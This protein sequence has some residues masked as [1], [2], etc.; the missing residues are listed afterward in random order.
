[1]YRLLIVDDEPII[2]DG[3]ID[4]FSDLEGFPELELYWAYSAHEALAC[5]RSTRIDIVLSDIEMPEMNGLSLQKEINQRWPRC[6][7]IFLTGYNDFDYIHS[8][9][10]NGATDYVLKTEGDAQILKAVRKAIEALDSQLALEHLLRK[11]E[12]RLTQA[13]PLLQREFWMDLL[14][15]AEVFQSITDAEARLRELHIPLKADEP[16]LMILGRVDAWKE[17]MS[18]SDKMLFLYAVHNIAEEYLQDAFRIVQIKYRQD[19]FVWLLQYKRPA[20]ALGEE[21]A[22]WPIHQIN[23]YMELIQASCSSYLNTPCSFMTVSEPFPWHLIAQRFDTLSFLFA[24]G[25]GTRQEVLLSDQQLFDTFR[26]RPDGRAQMRTVQLLTDF[27]EK[28][29]RAAFLALFDQFMGTIDGASFSRTGTAVEIFYGMVSMFI[30]YINRWALMKPVSD[31]F[32]INRLF[33]IEEHATWR[34]ATASFRQ[35]ADMLFEM[36]S[37]E[38]EQQSNEVIRKVQDYIKENLEGDL[39]LTRLAEAVYL[40]PSYLSKLYKQETGISLTDY[41]V[42]NRIQKAKELLLGSEQKIHKIGRSV[43]FESAAY[44]ARC[45]KKMTGQTPQEFRDGVRRG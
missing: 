2:V 39:S 19:R 8:S 44:F 21:T 6:K 15:G 14:S 43:G 28:G 27:L 34:E 1:M 42:D 9:S 29:H 35:L 25:L 33:S 16:L 31:R 10:R 11:A 32:N 22:G 30:T 3:L 20:A 40:S 45:F 7:V 26:E 24:R 4:F 12:G 23:G 41:I 13:L 5:L 38:S 18:Q 37:D 36:K 17:E